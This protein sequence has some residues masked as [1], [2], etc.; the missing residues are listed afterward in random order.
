MRDDEPTRIA[1]D[2]AVGD[3]RASDDESRDDTPG[4]NALSGDWA[5]TGGGL[6]VTA[7]GGIIP[8]GPP[9]SLP[10]RTAGSLEGGDER[11]PTALGGPGDL[12]RDLGDEAGAVMRS[13]DDT[14]SRNVPRRDENG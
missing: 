5:G 7:D 12:D 13:R 8:G 6:G 3:V 10:S 1:E 14:P 2:D 9:G 4:G 11:I